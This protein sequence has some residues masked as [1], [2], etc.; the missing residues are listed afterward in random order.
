MGNH[1][2]NHPEDLL[3][4]LIKNHPSVSVHVA[5]LHGE[6][7]PDLGLCCLALRIRQL[8]DKGCF[9]ATLSPGL[10]QV[11]ADGT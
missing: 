4:G 9:V 7:D 3:I 8:A 1:G 6:L 2:H 11:R 10:G 5:A